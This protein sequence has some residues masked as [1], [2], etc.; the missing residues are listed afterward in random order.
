MYLNQKQFLMRSEALKELFGRWNPEL[1]TESIAVSEAVGRVLS[2]AVSSV[3]TLP[4]CRSSKLDGI[5]VSFE[6]LMQAS[7]GQFPWTGTI[8]H[9]SADT[10]DDFDDAFDT[11]IAVER[12][13]RHSDGSLTITS[14]EPI[15]QGQNIKPRGD[16]L[17]EGQQ[18]LKKDTL[19]QP[20]H[21]AFLSTA[22]VSTV[23][24]YKKP[25][26][27]F[28]PT[29]N[30]L[31]PIGVSPKRGQNIES[32]SLMVRTM[33]AQ[34]G[35][36]AHCCPIVKDDNVLMEETLLNACSKADIVLINGGSSMGSEDYASRLLQKHA[37]WFQHGIRCIPG[38]PIALAIIDKKPVINLPGPTL[39]SYY[40]MDWC[41]KAMV[42]HMLKQD[43]PLR[44]TV[45]AV[46]KQKVQKPSHL[47]M[48][49]RLR[50]KCING[51]YTA[52]VL[53]P[54]KGLAHLLADC[55][56][57]FIAPIGKETFEEREIVRAEL[58]SGFDA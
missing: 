28:I 9:V 57:L 4:V 56:A 45:R 21:L 39:A 51:R 23:K 49:V 7:G 53:S 14:K 31:I 55:N 35:A 10:G 30:E 26:V 43:M 48:Y 41:V 12:I 2:D 13:V 32:N 52:E 29:G 16:T 50:V 47:E 19:L 15:K 44:R 46:L 38:I 5:A 36:K 34:W 8:A 17:K 18:L 37:E 42:F 6:A 40:A 54:Q 33:L 22:G 24:V 58:L 27:S 3:N 20:V 25:V 11:V 1:A